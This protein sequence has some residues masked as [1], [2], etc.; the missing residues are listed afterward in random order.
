MLSSCVETQPADGDCFYVAVQKAVSESAV[1]V[2][3]LRRNVASHLDQETFQTY[4]MMH[5]ARVE[6]FDWLKGV[7]DLAALRTA[8]GKTSVVTDH[9]IPCPMCEPCV[10]CRQDAGLQ[11]CVVDRSY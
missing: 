1:T 10:L 8:V 11:K 7:R 5:Q 3:A 4:Q 2:E 6:G 9:A